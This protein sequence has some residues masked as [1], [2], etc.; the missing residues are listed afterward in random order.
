MHVHR[1]V[2]C[3]YVCVYVCD[4]CV[5]MCICVCV[6]VYVC[7]SVCMHVCHRTSVGVGGALRG[8]GIKLRLSGLLSKHVLHGAILPTPPNGFVCLFVSQK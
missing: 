1:C 4:V 2:M 5:C 7:V 3:V 8:S 6:C